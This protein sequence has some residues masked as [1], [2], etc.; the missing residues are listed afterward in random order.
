MK[1][2]IYGASGMVGQGALL[3]AVQS[4]DVSEIIVIG[5]RALE[6]S[7]SKVKSLVLE[8]MHDH[9]PIADKLKGYD[10][11]FF[12]LGTTSMGKT[13]EEYSYVTYDLTWHVIETLLPRNPNMTFIYVS[14]AGADSSEKG[15]SMW[16]RVRGRLENRLFSAGF[17]SAH[18]MRPSYI[19]PMDGIKSRTF[20][21]RQLYNVVGAL[22]PLAKKIAPNS[23]TTTR[24]IGQAMLTLARTHSG[25]P[26][27]DPEDINQFAAK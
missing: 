8:N 27:L 19:Q 9:K 7:S 17:K 3:E 20:M 14:A 11:C 13:E 15:C 16:A 6:H 24:N 2:I 21:Y 1:L 4:A 10:A 5:R 25:P 22:F 23:L 26:I 12:S 18:S